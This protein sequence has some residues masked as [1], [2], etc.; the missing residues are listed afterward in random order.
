MA[1]ILYDF[2]T[3]SL[4]FN[5]NN[6]EQKYSNVP[7]K[8]LQEELTKYREYSIAQSNNLF[9]EISQNNHKISVTMEGFNSFLPNESVLKQCALYV[10]T[11]TINDPVFELTPTRSKVDKVMNEYLG[12]RNKDDDEIDRAELA[13]AISYMKRMIP[14]VSTE[15][16]K[17][18]PMSYVHEPPDELPIKFSKSYFS[19]ILPQELL[20]WL[21]K[22][23]KVSSLQKLDSG[24]WRV[25]NSLYASRSIIIDFKN[26]TS[27]KGIIYQL[28]ENEFYDAD[29]KTRR[30][31]F[32]SHIPDTPPEIRYFLAWV[33]QSENQAAKV[34]YD[35]IM[36]ELYYTSAMG[37]TYFT[38]SPF[39]AELINFLGEKST[40]F[41]TE[42]LNVALNLELPTIQEAS[43]ERIMDIRVNDGEA[44][45]NFRVE[46]EKQLRDLRNNLDPLQVGK[47][48]Q[49]ISHELEE[50][51]INEIKKKLAHLKKTVFAETAFWTALL[52]ASPYLGIPG[53]LTSLFGIG[54]TGMRA[55]NDKLGTIKDSPAYFLWK[56]K[57]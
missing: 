21:R 13:K 39:I 6:V 9:Q 30:I 35:Q 11:V 52:C 27:G 7:T 41:N 28:F 22:R 43:L 14:A 5:P 12:M 40:G 56:V 26:H 53:I 57:K 55:Y 3:E 25:L 10:D 34:M 44:F 32:K 50:V 15:F 38:Q 8:A 1:K 54:W 36:A 29:E 37:N 49:N 33:Y 19:D 24:G 4:L 2:L 45:Q 17:F 31:K 51:Q 23:I 20:Q 47:K 48:L 16:V 46:L 18:F 42:I